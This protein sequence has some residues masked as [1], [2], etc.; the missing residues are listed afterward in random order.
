MDIDYKAATHIPFAS[1]VL[2]SLSRNQPAIS[3]LGWGEYI[4]GPGLA[5]PFL[6]EPSKRP[7]FL[8]E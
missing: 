2:S 8:K 6:G 4:A 1:T 5:K 7:P 3:Y